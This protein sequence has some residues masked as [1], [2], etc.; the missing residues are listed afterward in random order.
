MDNVKL[1][2]EAVLRLTQNLVFCF[3]YMWICAH[4]CK[5]SWKPID[6]IRSCETGIID[7]YGPHNLSSRNRTQ[8]VRELN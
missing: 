8:V 1:K 4:V 2:W 7:K 3:N 6:G 5:L